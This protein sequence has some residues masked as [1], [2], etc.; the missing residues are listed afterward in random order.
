MP[1]LLTALKRDCTGAEQALYTS[2]VLVF[3]PLHSTNRQD[4]CK[5]EEQ[6]Q[7]R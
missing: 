7:R 2:D 6:Q 4:S 3:N 1:W 5:R